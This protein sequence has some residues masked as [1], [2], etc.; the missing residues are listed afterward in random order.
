MNLQ[1]KLRILTDF[2][3]QHKK[4]KKFAKKEKK[5]K[6]R[7]DQKFKG[8]FENY[9]DIYRLHKLFEFCYMWCVALIWRKEVIL[10]KYD[11]PRGKDTKRD[12]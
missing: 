12:A 9:K 6:W 7:I 2:L 3:L 5:E 8:K 10:D 4:M 11:I 1:H